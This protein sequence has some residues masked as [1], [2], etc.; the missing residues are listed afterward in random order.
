[1]RSK[2]RGRKGMDGGKRHRNGGLARSSSL[3]EG[4]GDWDGTHPGDSGLLWL[5]GKQD[6][7][8]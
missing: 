5:E 1:M 2:T 7:H 6:C 3:C 4:R 8:V